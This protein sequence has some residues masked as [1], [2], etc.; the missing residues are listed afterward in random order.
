MCG[1]C[2]YIGPLDATLDRQSALAM[3]DSLRHRGPDGAGEAPLMPL[4]GGSDLH[5]WFG[6]RRLKVMDLTPAAEQPMANED[7]SV[8]LTYNGEV[9][10]F[11]ELRR[12]LEGHGFRFRSN[13]D[14]EAVLRA[15]QAFGEEFVRRLD[16]MFALAIWDA[17]RAR[18]I[19]A[20]DRVGKKPLFYA[21]ADDRIAFASELKSLLLCPWVSRRMDVQRL[22][23]YLTFGYVPS[24]HTFY[25]GV[26]QVPP[27]S[28]LSFDRDGLA[29]PCEYWNPLPEHSP[30]VPVRDA[31]PRVAELL[32][33]AT[34]RRMMSDVPL[35]ALLSGGVDSSIVVG[36]MSEASPSRVHTF[37]IG[38]PD[39]PSFD[40]RPTARRVADHFRTNHTEFAV[41]L[42][43]VGL[44]DRLLWHHDQPYADSS[45]IPTYIVSRLARQHVTVVLNG[46]GG[47]EVFGGYDRFVAAA[48]SRRL[49]QRAARAA[50]RA[51]GM[52]RR[53][54]GYYSLR[55]RAERFLELAE[56][57][58]T[59]RYQSWIA[60]ANRALLHEL[61]AP[62]LRELAA[63]PAV[64]GSMLT[65]Y[66][67][68]SDLPYLDQ[69]LFA[70]FKTYLPDDLAVKMDRMSM[71]HS[72]EARSP[73]LDTAL[74]EY[75]ARVP[76]QAKV[77]IR[78]LKPVLR[79]AFGPLLPDSIWN[80]K[81]HGFGVPMGMWMRG[82]LGVMFAD[83]VLGLGARAGDF[84]DTGV[85][86]RLWEEHRRGEREHGSRLWT[87]LTLERWLRS[88]ERPLTS[89]PPP[90]GEITDARVHSL[91]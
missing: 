39:E 1:I 14:T 31:A 32:R 79:R 68:A 19:L 51:T 61:L 47:D 54:H 9:Y 12:E 8:V 62:R 33:S 50:R 77:G 37:S 63:P 67:R 53:N 15:Y 91:R 10:N 80:R 72:L 38:F 42:D 65:Q 78:R 84:I 83:E 75:A 66:E 85:A 89:E 36:L 58:V 45:A 71:A 60:V 35:G 29:G 43:A 52:L 30:D 57:P 2:G 55:R 82:E 3:R 17:R 5:G 74:I 64:E 27:A 23:E 81:K 26:R 41:Q 11:R 25:E 7:G 73:F 48:L 56:A 44:M 20:R 40:E 76:A 90:E 49:P 22:P 24:P 59:D 34:R 69:I 86:A 87:L 21:H 28:V 13:G 18:L 46:D 88:L 4:D 16:G 6:H 70:N